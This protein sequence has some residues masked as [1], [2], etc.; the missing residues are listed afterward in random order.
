MEGRR[1]ATLLPGTVTQMDVQ[2]GGA[3]KVAYFSVDG[4]P[5]Q[6]RRTVVEVAN[7][8]QCHFDL[9]ASLG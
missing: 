1:T 2:Y 9:N 8:N 3:N 7:C 5:V 4:S 6:S